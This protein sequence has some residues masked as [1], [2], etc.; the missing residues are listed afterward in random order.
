MAPRD[1]Q[2]ADAVATSESTRLVGVDL[3]EDTSDGSDSDPDF[4]TVAEIATAAGIVRASAVDTAAAPSVASPALSVPAT[5]ARRSRV[6]YTEEH[7]LH[8]MKLCDEYQHEY[9]AGNRTKFFEK[10][11]NLFNEEH[12]FKQVVDSF[13]RRFDDVNAEYTAGRSSERQ[14]ADALRE[15]QEVACRVRNQMLGA[16]EIG[17]LSL[18]LSQDADALPR[19]REI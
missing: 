16:R 14:R 9:T 5:P 12:D 8:I 17:L 11:A 7:K 18:D 19:S 6:Y 13:L 4:P 10:I 2:A 15:E 3:L 1:R